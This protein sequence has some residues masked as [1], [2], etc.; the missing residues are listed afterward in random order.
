MVKAVSC[1]LCEAYMELR[2]VKGSGYQFYGCSNFRSKGCKGRRNYVPERTEIVRRIPVK[3]KGSD[4]QEVI[5]EHM[6][7]MIPGDV[8]AAQAGAGC[9][10]TSTIEMGL[11]FHCPSSWRVLTLAFN[12]SIADELQARVP[13]NASAMTINSFGLKQLK[14]AFP[15]IRVNPLK[16]NEIL[17]RW[18]PIVRAQKGERLTQDDKIQNA[19]HHEVISAIKH[20][21]SLCKAYLLDGTNTEDLEGF[22][23]SHGIE[24]PDDGWRDEIF[25]RVPLAIEASRRDTSSCDFDDQ[26]WLPVILGLK[27]QTYDLVVIDEAQDLNLVKRVLVKLASMG[28]RLIIV[29]DRDQAIYAFSGADTNSITNFL[30]ELSDRNI[31][32]LPLMTTFRCSKA[33]VRLANKFVPN[34]V[35]WDTNAEGEIF[36]VDSIE[37]IGFDP[38]DMIICRT[39]NPLVA[40]AF[41]LVKLGYI[42]RIQGKDF[43]EEL[44]QLVNR[45]PAT[46]PAALVSDLMEYMERQLERM[47]KS[48]KTTKSSIETFKDKI[49]SLVEIAQNSTS[50]RDMI[51]KDELHPDSVVGKLKSMFVSVTNMDDVDY[52]LLTTG[53]KAKGLEAENIIIVHPE[54]MPHPSAET[55]EEKEQE[56]HLCYV[57]VTRSK[58]NIFFVGGRPAKLVGI[59]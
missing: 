44:I 57:A 19:I 6:E 22:V 49:M 23:S 45:F 14:R 10:K 2:T 26:I 40:V 34:L 48:R 17:E 32:E 4:E 13:E 41:R 58:G 33:A 3:R 56:D 39:N 35:A 12:K 47:M 7:N 51:S 37:Q 38:K 42:V 30:S 31:I 21:V 8:I 52:V 11:H 36:D 27:I 25:F 16:M 1:P 28:G 46:T 5:W 50:I 20:L 15:N 29:G 59:N 53:H 9:G 54:L 55:P 18:Y 43:A 24:I